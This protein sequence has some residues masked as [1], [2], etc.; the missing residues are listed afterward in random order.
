[1]VSTMFPSVGE[2]SLPRAPVPRVSGEGGRTVLWLSGEYDVATLTDM[3]K[4]LAA[5]IALDD[6]DLVVDL[7]EVQF[8]DVATIGLL[9]RARNFLR[10]RSRQLTLRNPPRCAQ[11]ILHVCGLSGLIDAPPADASPAIASSAPALSS[12]VSVPPTDRAD[13][14][15]GLT[16]AVV[17]EAVHSAPDECLLPV[18]ATQSM[19]ADV[20]AV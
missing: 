16:V 15:G 3:A 5:A 6:A 11:L 7:T 10:L 14:S 9:I 1:M 13:P 8:I 12:W 19:G 4:G 2:S 18:T 20:P 17:G